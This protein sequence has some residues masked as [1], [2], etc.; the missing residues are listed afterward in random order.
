MIYLHLQKSKRAKL[1]SPF[2]H[3]IKNQKEDNGE[4]KH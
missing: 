2:D 3:I 4:S 1:T